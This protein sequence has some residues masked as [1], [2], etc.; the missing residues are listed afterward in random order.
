MRLASLEQTYRQRW[1]RTMGQTAISC[2]DRKLPGSSPE[3]RLT[4]PLRYMTMAIKG[5]MEVSANQP[6]QSIAPLPSASPHQSSRLLPRLASC[7]TEYLLLCLRSITH[8]PFHHHLNFG[9]ANTNNNRRAAAKQRVMRNASA[10]FTTALRCKVFLLCAS[11]LCRT[12][13][14]AT[15]TAAM[16]LFTFYPTSSVLICKLYV[17]ALDEAGSL[18]ALIIRDTGH[19]S[20]RRSSTIKWHGD[21]DQRQRQKA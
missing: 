2:T 19:R 4:N 21:L 9:R 16:D 18:I 14:T 12:P 8:Y 1:V 10:L 3:L 17:L 6:R 15:T 7:R 11:S 5:S 13:A 20:K